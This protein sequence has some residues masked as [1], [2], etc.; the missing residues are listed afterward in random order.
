MLG[1]HSGRHALKARLK[2]LG[3]ELGESELLRAFGRFKDLC[4]KKKEVFDEDLVAIVEDEVKE[5]KD[6]WTLGS[7]VVTSG[8]DVAPEV[9]MC[10]KSGGRSYKRKATGDGP[11]NAC[12]TAIDEATGIKGQLIHYSI[13]SVT[14]G[15][16]ALGEV[17]VRVD[18]NGQKVTGIGASTDVIQASVKAYLNALNKA[19]MAATAKGPGSKNIDFGL[20]P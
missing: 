6:I 4:D 3:I 20:Q 5:I 10:L 14:E 16:D 12:Y 15:Q 2:H 1:K 19:C 11:V 9:T 7:F 8:T 13:Q 18:F 17:R